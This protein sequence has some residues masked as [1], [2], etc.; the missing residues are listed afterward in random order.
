MSSL[1]RWRRRRTSCTAFCWS[2]TTRCS[3]TTSTT[4]SCNT[5]ALETLWTFS[6]PQRL[7]QDFLQFHRD[8][9][10]RCRATLHTSQR[11]PARFQDCQILISLIVRAQV[12]LRSPQCN[13]LLQ[14]QRW[15]GTAAFI[16][17]NLLVRLRCA[18]KFGTADTSRHCRGLR[19]YALPSAHHL[20]NATGKQLK[21]A[22]PCRNAFG[23]GGLFWLKSRLWAS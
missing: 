4:C 13:A 6:A 8:A 23:D 15:G 17:C 19:I 22:S 11:A 14:H 18:F 21:I 12:W 9:H 20:R 1:M 7:L 10:N 5:S 3:A 2:R 16:L